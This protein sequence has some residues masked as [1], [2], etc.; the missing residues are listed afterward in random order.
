M[1]TPANKDGPLRWRTVGEVHEDTRSITSPAK[2]ERAAKWRAYS[3][4]N[5]NAGS[6]APTGQSLYETSK[7]SHK[8][9]FL[10]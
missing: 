6:T 1:I 2:R 9:L 8:S 5:E 4:I 10:D 7:I 3:E